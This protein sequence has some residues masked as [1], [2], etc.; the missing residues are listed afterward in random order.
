MGD[1]N[2]LESLGDTMKTTLFLCILFLA[3]CMT[4]ARKLQIEFERE[5]AAKCEQ[6]RRDMMESLAFRDNEIKNLKRENF[7][8]A[9]EN[10]ELRAMHLLK[11]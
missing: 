2:W 4:P 11:K 7:K 6:D 9:E 10:N 3:G 8:L 5:N 1:G